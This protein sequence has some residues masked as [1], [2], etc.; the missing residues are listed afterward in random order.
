LRD[1]LAGAAQDS[2]ALTS[3]RL[4]ARLHQLT[5]QLGGDEA[6][7]LALFAG[8]EVVEFA[9]ARAR[10]NGAPLSLAALARE[11]PPRFAD[12]LALASRAL[13]L[14]EAFGLGWPVLPSTRV[15]SPFGMRRHPILGV[16]KMH[17]GVDLSVSL[18]TDV[19]AAEDGVVRR[20]SEDP[21]NGRVVIIDHGRGVTTAYCHNQEL[22]VVLG[23]RVKRGQIISRSGS[24]GRS[25]G[26]HLHYQLE[27][28]GVPVDPL[29]FRSG[30]RP[31]VG[32][33]ETEAD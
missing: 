7:M 33:G 11:L 1:V 3:D 4:A 5:Y 15:S 8:Q 28:G 10:A 26:P 16:M 24:S 19:V 6:G 9:A 22:L 2:S 12:R 20:V 29:L 21:V 18:G 13:A 31:A 30:D 25:T 27:L 32:L 14:A 23:E 17:T